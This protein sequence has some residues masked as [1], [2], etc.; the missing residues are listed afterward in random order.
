M[1][2]NSGKW[3]PE[4]CYEDYSRGEGGGFTSG[5][6]FIDVPPEHS[7]PKVLFMYEARALESE[8]EEELEKEIILHSYANMLQLKDKLSEEDYDKVREA[9]G[10][11]PLS[12]AVEAGNKINE[13]ISVNLKETWYNHINK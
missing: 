12:V 13:K 1:S 5:I 8:G 3:I 9:L 11:Q 2:K 6:P 4:I 7:M 10:L